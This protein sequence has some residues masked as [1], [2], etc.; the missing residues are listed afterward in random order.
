MK[1]LFTQETDWLKRNPVQQHH[2]AEILSLRGHEIRVIDH[3]LQWR[4]AAGHRSHLKRE[5]YNIS[6]IYDGA[7]VTVIRPGIIKIPCLDY[8]SL[9]FSHRKEI[10]RQIKE[11][12]P[13]VIVGFG[14]L[15]SYLAVKAARKNNIPF[16]YYWID[17]LHRL[18][19]ARIFQP[20]G[21]LVEGM[22]LRRSDMVLS[23]NEKL[24][25]YVVSL[26]APEE[27]THVL[28]TGINDKLFNPASSVDSSLREQYGFSSEDIVLFFMGWLYRFSGLKEVARQ[29]TKSE[30]RNVKLLIVGE[31][32]LYEEL[33]KIQA[34]QSLQD[35]LI[36]TG[37]KDYNEMPTLISA[38][39]ICIL[40]SYPDEKIMK[41]IVPIKMYEYMAMQKPVIAT[42]LP[43]VMKEFGDSNGVVYVDGPEDVI[44]KA[45]ELVQGHNLAELGLKAREFAARNSWEKIADEFEGILE[46][47]I[48]RKKA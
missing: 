9:I 34:E 44:P 18:I 38:A 16:V 43:G 24:K 7:Q 12:Y 15:N 45:R 39:D 36:L 33:K 41:D 28:H 13:D 8:I 11:F 10:H 29:L 4:T 17:V 5:I 14:I 6:K 19:P 26:G 25:D 40:P 42:R 22:A 32:D 2:L 31:G 48:K 3:E 20:I 21:V 47:T 30:N 1:I 35:R 23:I 46:E 37:K 27:R